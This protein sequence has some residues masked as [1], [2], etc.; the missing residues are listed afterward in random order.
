ML[1]FLD[2]FSQQISPY[3]V[4]FFIWNSWCR[5]FLTLPLPLYAHK[6]HVTVLHLA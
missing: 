1:L 3:Y 2:S 5:L 4:P 6:A